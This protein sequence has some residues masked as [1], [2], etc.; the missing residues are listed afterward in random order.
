MLLRLVHI[1]RNFLAFKSYYFEA[2]LYLRIKI[3]FLLYLVHGHIYLVPRAPSLLHSSELRTFEFG[4]DT[5]LNKPQ[6]KIS[7]RCVPRCCERTQRQTDKHKDMAKCKRPF[8]KCF[9]KV[10]K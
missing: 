4:R 9:L 8:R 6:Y 1:N 7:S 2:M 5:L 10:L 3:Y